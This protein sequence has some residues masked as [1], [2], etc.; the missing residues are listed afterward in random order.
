MTTDSKILSGQTKC[1]FVVAVTQPLKELRLIMRC[2]NARRK[3]FSLRG[4]IVDFSRGWPK[5]FPRGA[6]SGEVSFYQLDSTK[7]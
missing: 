1:V 3:D 6:N 4:V 7:G 2:Y 5:D